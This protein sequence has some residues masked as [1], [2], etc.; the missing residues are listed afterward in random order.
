MTHH[1]VMAGLVPAIHDFL[2]KAKEDVDA[3]DI[4]AFTRVHSPSKTGVNAL[5]DALCAGMTVQEATPR[6]L[7]RRRYRLARRAH[8]DTRAA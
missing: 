4:S 5:S 1:I 2:S 7:L 8:L 3:R 6:V